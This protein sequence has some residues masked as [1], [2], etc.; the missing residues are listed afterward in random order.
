[1]SSSSPES[2]SASDD[3]EKNIRWEGMGYSCINSN[4]VSKLLHLSKRSKLCGRRGY[5]NRRS[6]RKSE[7][8]VAKFR[9]VGNEV[10][11]VSG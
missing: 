2:C 3:F 8:H 1:M 11:Y 4:R 6:R 7:T 10:M 9:L 5:E